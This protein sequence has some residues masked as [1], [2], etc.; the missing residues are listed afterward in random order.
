M[1]RTKDLHQ[2]SKYVLNGILA[3]GTEYGIFLLLTYVLSIPFLA[4]TQTVSFCLGL[5]VSFLGSRLFTFKQT[6]KT[7]KRSAKV[8]MMSYA[9][10]AVL[11]LLISNVVIYSLVHYAVLPSWIAKVI[12]MV[13]VAAWNFI[14][15]KKLIFKIA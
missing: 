8:Q 1:Q 15:F 13:L 6:G 7:Y 4:F 2:L 5:L 11:N 14:I 10:L 12:T 3:F 9:T